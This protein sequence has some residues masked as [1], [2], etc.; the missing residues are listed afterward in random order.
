MDTIRVNDTRKMRDLERFVDGLRQLARIC[1][2]TS[3]S[4]LQ[5]YFKD[6][7]VGGHKSLWMATGL[8]G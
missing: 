3:I 4:S 5:V 1:N 6:G 2:V 7:S 8:F